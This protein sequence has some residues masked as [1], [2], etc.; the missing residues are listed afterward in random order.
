MPTVNLCPGPPLEQ[1]NQLG[2][3][4]AGGKLFTYAAGTTTKLATYTDSTG[5][6]PNANPVVLNSN[7][8]ASVWLI[9]GDAYKLVLS[10]ANDTDPPTN[11]FW[12]QDNIVGINDAAFNFGTI[13]SGDVIGNASGSSAVPGAV[14]MTSIMDAAFAPSAGSTLQRG[15]SVWSPIIQETVGRIAQVATTTV[16]AANTYNNGTAGVG[17]TLTATGNGSI[18]TIDGVAA[19]LNNVYLVKN[20]VATANNGLYKLTQVGDASH[21]YILTRDTTLDSATEFV[22]GRVICVATGGTINGASMWSMSFSGAFTVGTTALSFVRET[23]TG[24][25]TIAFDISGKPGS[26]QVYQHIVAQTGTFTTVGAVGNVVTNP[27]TANTFLM[28]TNLSG[29]LVTQGTLTISTGGS[30][31]FPNFTKAMASGDLVRITNQ[32]TADGT[33]AGYSFGFPFTWP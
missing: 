15:S 21:P 6:T 27:G 3:P 23:Q 8:E 33:G 32:A 4:L 5:G 18:G 24:T 22:A 1:F 16:L 29:S 26:A 9:Q 28:A 20:E 31:N 10:P 7:G 17:A 11:P 14:T 2:I 19:A 13:A 12:T 25:L 30:V